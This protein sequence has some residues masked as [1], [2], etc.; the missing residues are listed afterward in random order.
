MIYNQFQMMVNRDF[1]FNTENII[2]VRINDEISFDQFKNEISGESSI[3][4]VAGGSHIPGI[5]MSRSR[6]IY[7]ELDGQEPF[8]M[9]YFSVDEN[10]MEVMGLELIAGQNFSGSNSEIIINEKAVEV[11]NLVSANS[12]LNSIVFSGDSAQLRIVGVIRDFHYMAVLA[13]IGPMFLINEPERVQIAHIVADKNNPM[14]RK[15]IENGYAKISDGYKADISLLEDEIKFFYDLTF[16]DM[17]RIV[18]IVTILSVVISCMGLLGIATYS[19]ETRLKEVSIRKV[20]GASD[21][22]LITHLSKG[23]IILLLIAIVVASPIAWLVNNLWLQQIAYRV[24][25]GPSVILLGICT[26]VVFGLITILSQT[27][28]ARTVTPIKH[29]RIE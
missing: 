20:M 27:W 15:T 2:D 12:A 29:L 22:N 26:L 8:S 13:E 6:S 10:Y 17:M 14:V 4:A 9:D 21:G 7:K 11:L 18:F 19:I 28:K 3:W 16:G 5:G 1:G 23:F 25:F 24:N